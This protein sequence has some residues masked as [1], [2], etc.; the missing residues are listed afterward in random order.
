M[1][2]ALLLDSAY[3]ADPPA[4]YFYPGYDMFANLAA[5]RANLVADVYASE[6][7][8]QDDLYKTVFGPAHDGHFVYYPDLLTLIFTWNRPY[9]LVSISEDQS[10]LPEIKV[11]GEYKSLDTYSL[12]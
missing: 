4:D 3:K 6:Y 10:S 5:V 9:S 1:R 2:C 12:D 8:F 11:Y 7:A